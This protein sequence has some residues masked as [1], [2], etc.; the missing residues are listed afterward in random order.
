MSN[1]KPCR[2]S[3]F[4]FKIHLPSQIGSIDDEQKLDDQHQQE[5]GLADK[6][7]GCFGHYHGNVLCQTFML[8]SSPEIWVLWVKVPLNVYPC[9]AK[10]IFIPYE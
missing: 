2:E 6:N 1:L 3:S 4:T 5:G 8:S 9:L 7:T 10:V